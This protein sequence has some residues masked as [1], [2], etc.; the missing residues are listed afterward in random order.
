MFKVEDNMIYLTRGDTGYARLELENEDVFYPGDEV[1]L[2][3]KRT[4]NNSNYALQKVITVEEETNTL[5]LKFEP[6][7]TRLLSYGLYFYDIQLTRAVNGDVFTIV[8]PDTDN[9]KANFKLLK[10]V[11]IN[12]D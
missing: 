10:E 8:T 12:N 6:E 9:P 5:V 11:T 2:S 4:F 1:I 3:V 7:D